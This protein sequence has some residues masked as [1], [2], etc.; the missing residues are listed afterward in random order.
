MDPR[1][2]LLLG[3]IGLVLFG[4]GALAVVEIADE[5]AKRTTGGKLTSHVAPKGG[6]V[7]VPPETIAAE[8]GVYVDYY[9]L[10]RCIGSESSGSSPDAE[11]LAIA[12]C[13]VNQC[14]QWG[15]TI[16]AG[17]CR[18]KTGAGFYGAQDAPGRWISTARDPSAAD[19]EL[20][21][22]VLNG[23]RADNTGGATKFFHADSQAALHVKDPAKYKTPE[24]VI[25]A[26]GKEGYVVVDVGVSRDR[27]VVMRKVSAARVV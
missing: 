2:L 3:G 4:G 26:W 13:V 22:A 19:L 1:L 14:R 21:T 17:V 10:A 7:D 12:W 11:R 8:V 5:V 27:F 23:Q 15:T 16:T 24:A 9:S 6:F 20:A 18:G 25:A